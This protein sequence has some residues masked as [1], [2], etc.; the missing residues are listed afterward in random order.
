M[1]TT[2]TSFVD[3]V[4]DLIPEEMA[5]MIFLG[6]TVQRMDFFKVKE[7]WTV[8]L[9]AE[10]A[11]FFHWHS[12]EK[13]FVIPRSRASQTIHILNRQQANN[14]MMVKRPSGH[15]YFFKV[16]ATNAEMVRDWLGEA[17]TTREPGT[18][19]SSLYELIYRPALHP[20]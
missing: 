6:F 20:S 16:T 15:L 11:E 5:Q 3:I 12:E 17:T 9:T 13:H 10:T 18:I 1:N 19:I 14:L 8:L 2:V 4:P 7:G